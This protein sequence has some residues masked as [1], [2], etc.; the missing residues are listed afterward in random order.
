MLKGANSIFLINRNETKEK[1]RK[2]NGENNNNFLDN[3]DLGLFK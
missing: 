1:R 2:R 3:I